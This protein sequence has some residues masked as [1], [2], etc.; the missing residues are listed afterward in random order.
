MIVFKARREIGAIKLFHVTSWAHQLLR[1]LKWYICLR[2]EFFLALILTLTLSSDPPPLF[3]LPFPASAP[4][5][6]PPTTEKNEDCSVGGRHA[7]PG[8]GRA[9]GLQV[10]RQPLVHALPRRVAQIHLRARK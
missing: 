7:A 1:P 8:G 4:P 3:S 2:P 6:R 10:R 9:L 5:L